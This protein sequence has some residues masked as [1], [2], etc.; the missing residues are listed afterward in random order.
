VALFGTSISPIS[1]ILGSNSVFSNE[2]VSQHWLSTVRGRL[3]YAVVDRLYVYGTGGLA[4]G[5]VSTT[6]SVTGGVTNPAGAAVTWSGS[7]STTKAGLSVGGGAEYAFADHWSLKGEY[8]YF[9]LGHVS[10]PL[11]L[12]SNTF[13][14]VVFP[15]LG[16]TTTR[17]NG[18]MVR[19]GLNYKF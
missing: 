7:N 8:I 2:Q 16:N 12:Q 4:I 3:G 19:A 6:G 13:G 17:V 18:S 11:P 15:T 10:H 9:D 5:E 14:G 1:A